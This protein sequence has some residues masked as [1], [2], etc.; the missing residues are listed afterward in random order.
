MTDRITKQESSIP[1]QSRISLI[2]L[3]ELA[4]YWKDTEYEIR[5]MS[6][7]VSWSLDLLRDILKA[8]DMITKDIESVVEARD[9]LVDNNLWQRKVSKRAF[10]KLGNAVRFQGFRD[11]GENPETR[12][13]MSKIGHNL[14][15]NK[16][17]VEP[18]EDK[19]SARQRLVAKATA[20]YH[21]LE[22]IE[23]EAPEKL[24]QEEVKARYRKK[25]REEKEALEGAVKEDRNGQV[26]EKAQPIPTVKEGMNDEEW[27]AK[28][29][30]IKE[31]DQARMELEKSAEISKDDIVEG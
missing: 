13:E 10:V 1:I 24:S 25:M 8:N 31:R 12:D 29:V 7:L 30:E 14:M 4:K 22:A 18:Y 27:E 20:I 23:D 17:S 5:T 9:Y 21:E 28:C 19:V 3:A 11:R 2:S 15:H 16:H 26:S 6:Q